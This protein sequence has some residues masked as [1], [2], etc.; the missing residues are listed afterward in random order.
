MDDQKIKELFSDFHPQLSSSSQFLNRVQRN[1]DTVEALKQYNTRLRHR[2]RVAVA[3]A[4]ACGFVM[5]MLMTMLM[6][7]ISGMLSVFTITLPMLNTSDMGIDTGVL[8]W[9][10]IGGTCV[11]TAINAYEIAM[12]KFSTKDSL[13]RRDA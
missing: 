4:A 11:I 7:V 13:S 10:V 6:P 5:G 9:I 3:I 2:N 12:S 8:S 1:I